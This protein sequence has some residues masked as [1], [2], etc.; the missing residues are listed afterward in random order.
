MHDVNGDVREQHRQGITEERNPSSPSPLLQAQGSFSF[1]FTSYLRFNIDQI[2]FWLAS[3]TILS[4][5]P[6]VFT[7]DILFTLLLL[8]DLRIV[9]G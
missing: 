9:S 6:I 1:L 2:H 4:V 5:D 7:F 8:S 3:F